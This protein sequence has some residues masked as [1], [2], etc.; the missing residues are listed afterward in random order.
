MSHAENVPTFVARFS[1]DS[2]EQNC[3]DQPY[4]ESAWTII[5]NAINVEQLRGLTRLYEGDSCVANEYVYC[6][7]FQNADEAVLSRIQER[8][9]LDAEFRRVADSKP[10]AHCRSRTQFVALSLVHVANVKNGEVE[11][12]RGTYLRGVIAKVRA[13]RRQRAAATENLSTHVAASPRPMP[14]SARTRSLPPFSTRDDLVRHL[15]S[16][17]GAAPTYG[18]Y[19]TPEE[20]CDVVDHYS[21]T[22]QAFLS[23]RFDNG[24][25]LT[26]HLVA[27]SDLPNKP[28]EQTWVTNRGILFR[29]LTEFASAADAVNYCRTSI[30]D[31]GCVAAWRIQGKHSLN[32]LMEDQY[33][34]S[35]DRTKPVS[36]NELWTAVCQRRLELRIPTDTSTSKERG[37]KAE[38]QRDLDRPNSGSARRKKPT[39]IQVPKQAVAEAPKQTARPNPAELER[40]YTEA[41]QEWKNA[42]KPYIRLW[43][44][45]SLFLSLAIS[46]M[47][48]ISG[49]ILISQVVGA[50]IGGTLVTGFLLMIPLV[51][52][53]RINNDRIVK[54][55]LT[56]GGQLSELAAESERRRESEHQQRESERQRSAISAEL[57]TTEARLKHAD[58]PGASPSMQKFCPECKG[59]RVWVIVG[60][61]GLEPYCLNCSVLCDCG[62]R[63]QIRNAKR[64]SES[65][66]V[67]CPECRAAY[68]T[69]PERDRVTEWI[70][71]IEA[72][73]GSPRVVELL[74]RI[75]PAGR[76]AIPLLQQLFTKHGKG[77]FLGCAAYDALREHKMNKHIT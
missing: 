21:G 70:H 39:T 66:H 31:Q 50:F 58:L 35:I 14:A 62:R 11:T 74:G 47:S 37:Y 25:E 5:H 59:T 73:G 68:E 15:H 42:V 7:A 13:Y 18:A 20:L 16:R 69:V 9:K 2:V 45:S 52:V 60:A 26:L 40:E 72:T 56:L 3:P 55:K 30:G 8:L 1:I 53:F 48:V 24:E 71:L 28:I 57:R 49:D 46:V 23:R 36:A 65:G 27:R 75:G 76:P 4:G 44:V 19:L 22:T 10:F 34:E 43:M 51:I 32:F 63:F 54:R 64:A 41:V 6:I 67:E 29:G 12:V 33:T 77:N 61:V 38:P 17:F